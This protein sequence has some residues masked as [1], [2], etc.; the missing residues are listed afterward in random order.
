MKQGFFLFFLIV[1]IVALGQSNPYNGF[2]LDSIGNPV[3]QAN[4]CKAYNGNIYGSQCV[5]SDRLGKYRIQLS[6]GNQIAITIKYDSISYTKMY[7]YKEDPFDSFGYLTEIERIENELEWTSGKIDSDANSEKFPIKKEKKENNYYYSRYGF[8]KILIE[9]DSAR[10]LHDAEYVK[11]RLGFDFDLSYSISEHLN[12]PKLQNEFVQGRPDNG[13]LTQFGSPEAFSW[14][15]SLQNISGL[16]FYDSN[17]IFREADAFKVG[18]NAAYE[19]KSHFLN[20]N[21]STR[22]EEG[23]F[24]STKGNF[25]SFKINYNFPLWGGVMKTNVGTNWEKTEMPLIGNNYM[26]V[27]YSAWNSPFHFNPHPEILNGQQN[28]ASDQYNNPIFLINYNRDVKKDNNMSAGLDYSVKLKN[29]ILNGIFSF[30]NFNQNME[31]G[32]IPQMALAAN[33]SFFKRDFSEQMTN[34]RLSAVYNNQNTLKIHLN[35]VHQL[36]SFQLRKDIFTDY[37]SLINF[38]NDGISSE[39]YSVSKQRYNSNLGVKLDYSKYLEDIELQNVLSQT[40]YYTNTNDQ[41]FAYQVNNVLTID[42]RYLLG[43]FN[44]IFG[45]KNE[46]HYTEPELISQNLNF[47]SLNQN[48]SNFMDY[49]EPYELF[50]QSNLTNLQE[51]KMTEIMLTAQIGHIFKLDF[52]FYH[53]KINN[54]YSPLFNGNSFSWENVADYHQQGFEL[55]LSNGNFLDSGNF[56]WNFNLNFHAYKNKT[57]R[58]LIDAERVPYFGFN[59]ISKNFIEDQAV[60]VIV[61]S[62]FQRDGNGNVMIGSDGFP[63][64]DGNLKIIA[65]PNP[66]FTLKLFNE[67]KVH[68]FSLAFN[69]D[70]Q[71]GGQIWNGTQSTLN[72]FGRSQLTADLR[73]TTNYVFNGMNLNGQP[74]SIAVDFTNPANDLS[75]NRWVRYGVTGTASEN[76]EDASYFRLQNISLSYETKLRK[77][78]YSPLTKLTISIFARNL[79]V[80][81]DYSGV[82]PGT[83]L[84]GNDQGI[85]MDYFNYPLSRTYGVSLN[86]KF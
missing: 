76:V 58:I 27:L 60:G 16:N 62:D 57:D 20:F 15:P 46:I 17:K 4:I 21:A 42:S 72:Y 65:D 29:W 55:N 8:S 26:N 37:S 68:N 54:A 23:L 31:Y 71:K 36:N 64:V 73:N 83:G 66:D 49:Q 45:L 41:S 12:T 82:F 32:Q 74:N 47:N 48:I 59:D 67:I 40:L 6:H 28:S 34:L 33:P 24:E 69:F 63:I 38:P 51:K 53:F 80:S 86:L 35:W 25:Y 52:S 13:T 19:R 75:E 56:N 10:L 77:Y 30:S 43:D 79:W 50:L 22:Q 2:V 81:T 3:Y 61:G 7:E 18:F 1:H 44:L 85:G 84:L 39:L 70:W 11:G 14:G 5:V 9:N 78:H